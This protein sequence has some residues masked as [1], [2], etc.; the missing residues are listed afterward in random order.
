M[1]AKEPGRCY[2][3]PGGGARELGG[4]FLSSLGEGAFRPTHGE[5]IRNFIDKL[6][7]AKEIGQRPLLRAFQGSWGR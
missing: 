6:M 1:N 7:S 3:A 4:T 5:I 2:G